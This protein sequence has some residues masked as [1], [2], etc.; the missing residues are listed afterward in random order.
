MNTMRVIPETI[1]YGV[2]LLSV[3]IGLGLFR[4]ASGQGPAYVGAAKCKL[5]HMKQHKIW[6]ESKHMKAFED[7]KPEEQKDPKCLNC[8]VT[9]YRATQEVKPSLTGVQCEACHGPAADYI[10]IHPKKDKEGAR[11]AGMIAKPEPAAC[12]VCHNDQSPTFK[13]FDYA[14]LWETIKHPK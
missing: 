1:F 13:G 4:N 7:L 12:A 9:G 6:S 5:C 10:K 2:L 3:V 14:K 8:H 11:A